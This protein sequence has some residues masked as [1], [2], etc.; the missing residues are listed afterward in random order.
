MRKMLKDVGKPDL[1]PP[2]VRRCMTVVAQVSDN[3]SRDR[4]V[5]FSSAQQGQKIV[6]IINTVFA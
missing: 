6:V 1:E 4:R 2:Y 3:Q 5:I